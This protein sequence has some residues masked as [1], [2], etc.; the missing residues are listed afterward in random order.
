MRRTVIAAVAAVLVAWACLGA[1]T[2]INGRTQIRP[3]TVTRADHDTTT[4]GQAV[5][6]KVTAS[7]ASAMTYTGA[8]AGTGDVVVTV[9]QVR[10]GQSA[11]LPNLAIGGNTNVTITWAQGAFA[12]TNYDVTC[13]LVGSGGLNLG[14]QIVDGTKTATGVTV[15]VSNLAGISLTLGSYSVAAVAVHR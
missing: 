9:P 2:Q 11:A 5:V 13:T 4:S 8:D 10:S 15:N 14:L 3:G 12:D 6:T 1:A 7:P